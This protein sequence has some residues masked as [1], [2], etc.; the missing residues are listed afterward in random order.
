MNKRLVIASVG[1]GLAMA[2]VGG[3]VAVAGDG[4]DGSISH[5]YT[6]DQADAAERAAL[7]ATGGGT[8][9]SVESDTENGATYEVEVTDPDGNVVDVRLDEQYQVVVI[10][11]DSEEPDSDD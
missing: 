4:D 9:N 2:A 3:G 8:V 1:T 7:E 11:G 6:Q 10:E 5:Q